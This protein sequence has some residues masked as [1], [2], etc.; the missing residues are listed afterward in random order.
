[1]MTARAPLLLLL[2]LVMMMTALLLLLLLLLVMTTQ[3]LCPCVHLPGRQNVWDTHKQAE[4]S[5]SPQ[6]SCSSP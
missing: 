2:L 5:H 6:A 4:V 3:G 1:M